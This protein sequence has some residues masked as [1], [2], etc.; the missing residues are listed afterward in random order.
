MN[1]NQPLVRFYLAAVMGLLGRLDEARSAVSAGLTFNPTFT[2]SRFRA[3]VASDNPTYL[4]RR[5]RVYKGMQIAG[6]PER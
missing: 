3:G 2:V 1:R 6:V 4:A 5:E